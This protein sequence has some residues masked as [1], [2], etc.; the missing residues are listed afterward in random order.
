[1]G[2]AHSIVREQAASL[3]DRPRDRAADGP[4]VAGTLYHVLEL[5]AL[6]AVEG[7]EAETGEEARQRH[8]DLGVRGD[9]RLLR[10]LDVRPSLEKLRRQPDRHFG[11]G[12]LAIELEAADDFAWRPSE[13]R[14]ELILLGDDL[15]LELG[16]VRARLSERRRRARHL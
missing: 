12:D 15:A 7:R 6:A 2:R 4:D 16:D 9:E 3:E 1:G 10:L 13:E 8:T 11:R 14:R 5:A